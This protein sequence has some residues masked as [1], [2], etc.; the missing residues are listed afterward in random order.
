VLVT[1]QAKLLWDVAHCAAGVDE[2]DRLLPGGS[3]QV[4][5][6]Q[7]MSLQQ[8]FQPEQLMPIIALIGMRM[9]NKM[10]AQG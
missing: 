9:Q 2:L 3:L 6:E 7:V 5:Q 10:Q 8:I 4:T 1:E